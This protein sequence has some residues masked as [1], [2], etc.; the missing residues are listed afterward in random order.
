LAKRW[1]LR[2]VASASSC[3]LRPAL[4]AAQAGEAHSTAQFPGLRVLPARDGDGFLDGGLGLARRPGAG[5]QRLAPEPI[6]FRF[7]RRSPHLFDRL[8]PGGDRYKCCF[9]LAGRQLR[10]G[11]QRQQPM[12]EHPETV[13]VYRS[14]N[15][16]QRFLA[17]AGGAERPSI[18]AKGNRV[19]GRE[20]VLLADP[21]SPFGIIGSRRR[22]AAKDVNL[23]G[24]TQRLGE[25]ERVPQRQQLGVQFLPAKPGALVLFDDLLEEGA[26]QVGAV[27]VGRTPGD[28]CGRIGDQVSQ[29][30]RRP[31]GRRDHDPRIGAQ[32]QPE[33][34]HVPGLRVAPRTHLVA[35]GA[36][37]L[38]AA[39]TLGLVGRVGC[40]NGPV[41]PSQPALGRLIGRALPGWR[42][43]QDAAFAFDYDVARI[44][45]RRGDQRD[46]P[47]AGDNRLMDPFGPA[48]GLAGTAV[49]KVEPSSP[50]TRWRD[51][52]VPGDPLEPATLP[53]L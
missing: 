27:L 15:L 16:G 3:L 49:G 48:T 21:Q 43:R 32:A 9:G 42:H 47:T 13:A 34:Q 39:Q 12:L 2:R 17:L 44:G 11:L 46:A 36:I 10:I 5:E 22:L 14:C 25:G 41:G 45:R 35:P 29:Q 23:R 28:D 8:Q 20:A 38:R 19:V 1:I 4:L 7:K 24:G 40:R 52:L 26:G 51:L 18:R 50:I 37:V 30:A 33:H 31:R 53:P 6:E